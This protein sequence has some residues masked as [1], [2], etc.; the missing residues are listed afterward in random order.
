MKDLFLTIV[1]DFDPTYHP[2]LAMK[3]A[4]KLAAKD[5]GVEVVLRWVSTVELA[6]EYS[7][8]LRESD[9]FIIGPGSA[10]HSLSG[11]LQIIG[12]A[13]K[14]Q[15]PLLGTC[16]GFQQ[17]LVEYA[18]EVAGYTKAYHAEHQSGEGPALISLLD[19]PLDGKREL[20]KLNQEDS[21]MRQ[22]YEAAE[23]EEGFACYYGLNP[24]FR[25][26]IEEEG[27]LISGESDDGQVLAVELDQHPFFLG[28]LYV[29][30]L[31]PEG[32]TAH[33]L[34]AGLLK[35][36]KAYRKSA[37]KKIARR[38]QIFDHIRQRFFENGFYKI[39]MDEIV[40]ELRIS[41]STL[42]EFYRN[43]EEMVRALVHRLGDLLEA[44]LDNIL[45]HPGY[46]FVD[47]IMQI[48]EYQGAVTS[49]IHHRFFSDL[50][51]YTPEIWEEYDSRRKLRVANYYGSLIDHGIQS[52]V[53]RSDLD[54]NFLLQLY[55]KM[56]EMISYT[57]I[58]EH[59]PYQRPEINRKIME[60]FLNGTHAR[61]MKGGEDE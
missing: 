2:H 48:A 33:P 9:A 21:L 4:L 61:F 5:Q 34:L 26:L 22:S 3:K 53:L 8:L 52:G 20:V 43:K 45:T 58:L 36:A 35:A 11:A 16:G 40:R 10:S 44:E 47:K 51:L 24:R 13:R 38:E 50:R 59:S 31:E 27:L 14:N 18:R 37:K 7:Q 17:L 49:R 55:I 39:S 1:A 25:P 46:S 56:S 29:P 12:F 15:I 54:R 57:D 23:V 42:Y 32:D 30:H 6:T 41:K 19:E 28:T 60:V